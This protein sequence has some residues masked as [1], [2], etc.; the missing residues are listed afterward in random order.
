MTSEW[1]YQV[2]ASVIAGVLLPAMLLVME[3]G[4]RAGVRRRQRLGNAEREHI[5]AVQTSILGIL[6]LLIGFSFSLALH[7]YAGRSEDLVAEVNAI[8]STDN[9]ARVLPDPVRREVRERLRRYVDLRL[10]ASLMSQVESGRVTVLERESEQLVN[11]LNRTLMEKGVA[12]PEAEPFRWVLA[13]TER[14]SEAYRKRLAGLERHVPEAVW[15]ALLG[16]ILVAVAVV[17]FGAG[18][19]GHRPVTA[20]YALVGMIVVLVF[21]ILDL[22]RPR[23]G[24]IEVSQKPLVELR[25]RMEA[26]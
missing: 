23:R 22:D 21:L 14:I 15:F 3:L 5:G 9:R 7:R 26:R 11:E 24:L 12:G 20:S 19:G 25:L 16:S 2:P 6:A 1:L 17:G 8:D 13:G 18:V 10:E 4:H